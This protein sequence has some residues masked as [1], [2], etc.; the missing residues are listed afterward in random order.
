MH[1]RLTSAHNT[2]TYTITS[3]DH[4]FRPLQLRRFPVSLTMG[5]YDG[6]FLCDLTLAEE[7]R[8][9][10]RLTLVVDSD[11][12]QVR[13]WLGGVWGRTRRWC[14]RRVVVEGTRN[15]LFWLT[16]TP[17]SPP[18][19]TTHNSRPNPPT[20]LLPPEI[21]RPRHVPGAAGH[22]ADFVRRAAEAGGVGAGRGPA[23]AAG[24]RSRKRSSRAG[25]GAGG[26][27]DGVCTWSTQKQST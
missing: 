19:T 13:F 3:A 26:G 20:D 6:K 22:G 21:G 23:A 24:G 25:V 15:H 7:E 1:T 12:S 27:N 14:R 11:S 18:R 2:P 10:S 16:I 4:P 17:L 9:Q 8:V 5:L